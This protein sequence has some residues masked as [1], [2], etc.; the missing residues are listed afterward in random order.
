MIGSQSLWASALVPQLDG[1][2]R[3][4]VLIMGKAKYTHFMGL[5]NSH[6][7]KKLKMAGVIKI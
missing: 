7:E 2:P 6:T 4:M 1:L 3:D 5:N